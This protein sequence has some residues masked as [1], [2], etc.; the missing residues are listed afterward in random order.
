[1]AINIR[2]KGIIGTLAQIITDRFAGLIAWMTDI[3]R[4]IM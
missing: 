3:S 4:F 1:M 2:F